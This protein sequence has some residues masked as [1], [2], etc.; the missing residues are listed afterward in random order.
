M[1]SNAAL[2][3]VA[4]AVAPAMLVVWWHL[5]RVSWLPVI[6]I[7]EFFVLEALVHNLAVAT[8]VPTCCLDLFCGPCSG[9]L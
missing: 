9:C 7:T 1:A 5:L 3:I 6:L 8:A 2:A 4:S